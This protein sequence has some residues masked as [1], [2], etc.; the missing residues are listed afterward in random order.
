[1]WTFYIQRKL[2]FTV[3][4]VFSEAAGDTVEI[5][6][7]K[8]WKYRKKQLLIS[9]TSLIEFVNFITEEDYF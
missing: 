2:T 1:M 9:V 4:N 8:I 7:S 6:L 3:L 5:A